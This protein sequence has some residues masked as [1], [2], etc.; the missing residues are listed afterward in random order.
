[1]DLSR[2]EVIVMPSVRDAYLEDYGIGLE[3]GKAIVDMCKHLTGDQLNVLEESARNVCPDIANLLVVNLTTGI[4]YD[5]L[6]KKHSIPM[7]RKDF[8]GYRRKT[9]AE[10]YRKIRLLG[11]Y[12]Y[13]AGH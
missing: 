6:S 2:K 3:E 8:Q 13:G 1:M 12:D 9:I 11:F 10:F 5:K 7:Q 4:G